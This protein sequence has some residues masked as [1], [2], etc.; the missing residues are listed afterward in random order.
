MSAN[1][2]LGIKGSVHITVWQKTPDGGE[3]IIR[4]TTK[5]NLIV[6][7]G[8]DSILKR[9][10]GTGLMCFGEAGGVGVG[11]SA[12]VAAASN[13]DLLGCMILWK[14]VS[15]TCKIYVRPTLFVSVDF[16]YTCANFT[17]NELGITD[18]QGCPANA[19]AC[20]STLWAR[21]VDCTPLVK[22]CTKRAIVEW[23]LTL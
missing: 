19:P 22:D 9:L 2:N 8:K 3:E 5:H 16:G 7:V 12:T 13:T 10:G 23:Q 14:D 21:Q 15:T 17:W 4:D 18:D 6:D 11:N 1:E 20:C